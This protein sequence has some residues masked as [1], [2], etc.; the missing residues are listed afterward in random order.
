MPMRRKLAPVRNLESST[1]QSSPTLLT[2]IPGAPKLPR[3]VH[4]PM[5]RRTRTAGTR[6][7]PR[8]TFGKEAGERTVSCKNTN[9][10]GKRKRARLCWQDETHPK[11]RTEL[12]QEPYSSNWRAPYCYHTGWRA[13]GTCS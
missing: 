5:M 6:V 2:T 10:F 4:E 12:W 13:H 3:P 9:D 7:L 8:N 1:Q 11:M